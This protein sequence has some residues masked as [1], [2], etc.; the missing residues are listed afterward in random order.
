[1]ASSVGKTNDYPPKNPSRLRKTTPPPEKSQDAKTPTDKGQDYTQIIQI[2]DADL[3]PPEQKP[4]TDK[5][6]VQEVKP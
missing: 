5:S 2:P 1:M 6:E 3:S 4:A